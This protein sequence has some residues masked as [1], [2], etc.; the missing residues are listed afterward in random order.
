MKSLGNLRGLYA[1]ID[2]TLTPH[3]PHPELAER[4]LKGGARI[5]QLRLKPSAPVLGKSTFSD[6]ELLE[7][8]KAIRNITR[9][10]KASFI[11]NDRADIALAAEADGLHLGQNDLPLSEARRILGKNKVIGISTHN[12][13][14]AERAER[15]GADYLGFGPVFST[16]TKEESLPP[17]GIESLKQVVAAIKLPIIAIG[18]INEKNIKDV[19]RTGAAGAAIISSITTAKDITE[20]TR[21]FVEL[22]RKK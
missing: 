8:A 4:V 22:L 9:Q 15:E 14:D 17:R 21:L 7:T 10:H 13:K 1:I 20:K 12:L 3:L 16:E 11:I 6:R 2:N 19:I 5:I 18:G